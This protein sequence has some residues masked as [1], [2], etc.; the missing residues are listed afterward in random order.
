MALAW[1]LTPS[2]MQ[3]PL[4]G[5]ETVTREEARLFF[6]L[7]SAETPTR[8]SRHITPCD[9]K[10]PEVSHPTSGDSGSCSHI[11]VTS[12][13]VRRLPRKD[14]DTRGMSRNTNTGVCGSLG[15]AL[16]LVHTLGHLRM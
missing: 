8:L 7:V 5:T 14:N 4:V 15:L 1:A 3:K 12:T 13:S 16:Y 9:A 11:A 6:N 10:A 2:R